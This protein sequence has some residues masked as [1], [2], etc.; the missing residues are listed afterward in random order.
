MNNNKTIIVNKAIANDI[1][2]G[3]FG[4]SGSRFPSL[5]SLAEMYDISFVTA[6]HISKMLRSDGLLYLLGNNMF[7]TYGLADKKSPFYIQYEKRHNSTKLYGL[8]LSTTDNEFFSRLAEKISLK[9]NANGDRLIMMSSGGNE[10]NERKILSEMLELGVNGIFTFPVSPDNYRYYPLPVIFLG[11]DASSGNTVQVNNIK[12][13]KQVAYHLYEQGYE[14]FF[15]IGTNKINDEND[16]RLLGYRRGLSEKGIELPNDNI[17][18]SDGYTYEKSHIL[19]YL[20][21]KLLND[22]RSAG[23]F[24]YHDLIAFS[25]FELC[26]R[27]RI[28]IP[29]NVGI[30]GFDDLQAAS[31][32][33]FDL[34]TIS[35]Q[36][37]NMADTAYDLMKDVISDHTIKKQLYISQYLTVRSS[38]QKISHVK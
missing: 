15:Y 34:S 27:S 7:I 36:Y 25:V 26:K 24:C 18:I 21:Y 23:I 13:G 30:V 35:Y 37:D 20:K 22:T 6:Q 2:N 38:S 28:D 14:R 5:R 8:H 9:L 31:T 29:H 17:I 11:R 19:H 3:K 32:L 16:M 12:A 10:N 4:V 33:T 1:L